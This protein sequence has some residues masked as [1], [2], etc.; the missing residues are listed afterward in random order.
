MYDRGKETLLR[1][2]VINIETHLVSSL[3]AKDAAIAISSEVSTETVSC[4]LK[5]LMDIKTVYYK[6]VSP[7]I[8]IIE[9]CWIIEINHINCKFFFDCVIWTEREHSHLTVLL[10]RSISF[11]L[12]ELEAWKEVIQAVTAALLTL[13]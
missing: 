10:F 8:E 13:S 1:H 2:G 4:N 6:D 12:K 5:S 9:D 11:T 7:S 3:T